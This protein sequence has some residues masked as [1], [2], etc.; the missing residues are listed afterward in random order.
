MS[1]DNSL[2]QQAPRIYYLILAVML[3][4]GFNPFRPWRV[5]DLGHI[6][7]VLWGPPNAPETFS[8]HTRSYWKYLISALIAQDGKLIYRK[9]FISIPSFWN[10]WSINEKEY[11]KT[12]EYLYSL[13]KDSEQRILKYHATRFNCFHVACECLKLAGIPAP[14]VPLERVAI[15]HAIKPKT[16]LRL[17]MPSAKYSVMLHDLCEEEGK[18]DRLDCLFTSL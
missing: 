9:N 5:F 2:T 10:S 16:F 17:V 13:K 6:D 15:V 12:Q 1:R 4:N 18:F 14:K 3:A 8:F 7:V 11:R